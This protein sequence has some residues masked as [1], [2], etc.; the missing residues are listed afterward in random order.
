[1]KSN[2]DVGPNDFSGLVQIMAGPG[3]NVQDLGKAEA[4]AFF[5]EVTMVQLFSLSFLIAAKRDYRRGSVN[6]R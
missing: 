5:G 1:M 2:K 6:A 3:S 4:R